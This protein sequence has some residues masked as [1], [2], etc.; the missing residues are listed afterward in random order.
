[1]S[2]KKS[3]KQSKI[4]IKITFISGGE[5]VVPDKQWNDYRYDGKFF[6]IIKDGADIAMYNARE[7]FSLI[8]TRH[9]E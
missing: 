5:I 4:D 9:G 7:V 6:T 2:K 1:M 8:L 3:K